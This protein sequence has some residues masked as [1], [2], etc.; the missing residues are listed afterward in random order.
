M[1]NEKAYDIKAKEKAIS[2]AKS[3]FFPH[4]DLK[5]SYVRSEYPNRVI[6]AHEN[7]Q[8]G[9]FNKDLFQGSVELTLPIFLGG[10]RVY[11]YKAARLLKDISVNIHFFYQTRAH[12]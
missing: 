9:I 3:D 1:L 6:F 8:P 2:I 7:N 12:L 5:G 10:K 11:N 4:I